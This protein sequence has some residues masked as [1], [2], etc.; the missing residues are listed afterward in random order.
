MWRDLKNNNPKE[1]DDAVAFDEAIRKGSARATA[2]GDMLRG[3]AYLHKSRIPLRIA[4][5]EKIEPMERKELLDDRLD[6]F[7]INIEED[8]A[9]CSPFGCR[10]DELSVGRESENVIDENDGYEL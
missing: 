5:V 1:W 6:I 10:A 3:E 9:G 4:D 8:L 7:D 2:N